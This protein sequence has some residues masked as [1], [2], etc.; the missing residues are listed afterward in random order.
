MALVFSIVSLMS[1]KLNN[2]SLLMEVDLGNYGGEN[3]S[4]EI[5]A[6]YLAG[7]KS[8]NV[9]IDTAIQSSRGLAREI[10]DS[11][12]SKGYPVFL[13][14]VKHLDNLCS[15]RYEESPV[16]KTK[17]YA[18]LNFLTVT[19]HESQKGGKGYVPMVQK[20]I[21]VPAS[22]EG[23]FPYDE[24]PDLLAT[25]RCFYLPLVDELGSRSLSSLI[26]PK[27][28]SSNRWRIMSYLTLKTVFSKSRNAYWRIA[29]QILDLH[30]VPLNT[31]KQ[32]V[33]FGGKSDASFFTE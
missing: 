8:V 14:S 9:L 27:E 21:A 5:G 29:T 20:S 19:F 4:A 32:A 12:L 6:A 2:H 25:W 24:L 22:P 11:H 3:T 17:G 15:I 31:T 7:E 23:V 33:F 10:W 13:K 1:L 18:H 26:P 16:P 30:R 28:V